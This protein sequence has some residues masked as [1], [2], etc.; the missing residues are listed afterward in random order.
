MYISIVIPIFNE[1]ASLEKNLYKI[2]NFFKNKKNF[3]IIVINDG[4][5]DKSLDILSNLTISNLI[6]LNNKKNIGKGASIRKGVAKSTGELLLITDADLSAPIEEF[7][8]L[9]KYYDLGYEVIVGSRSTKDANLIIKQG[10]I[11]IM[12]GK[13]F[14]KLVNLILNLNYRDTQCGFKLFSNDKLKK[15]MKISVVDRFAIDAEIL[16]LAQRLKLKTY[17][18]GIVWKDNSNSSVKL[19]SDSFNMFYDLLK[20]RL[21]NYKDNI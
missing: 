3:E 10:I 18:K 2:Y 11:R 4:S 13:I 17:E 12:S 5:N 15:I 21:T 7:N 1:E 16:Y 9:I 6:I 19:I 14:N 8:K 20:I